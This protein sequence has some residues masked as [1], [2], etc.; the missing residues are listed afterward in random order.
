TLIGV[1]TVAIPWGVLIANLLLPIVVFGL[2][3]LVARKRNVGVLAITFLAGLGV[4]G[5]LTLS[6]TVLAGILT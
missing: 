5:A 6:F 1:N 2:C 4:V 3:I